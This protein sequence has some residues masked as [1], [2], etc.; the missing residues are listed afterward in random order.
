[1]GVL[2]HY[3]GD[4]KLDR[5]FILTEN[6][7]PFGANV[8]MRLSGSTISNLELLNNSTSGT[9]KGSLFWVLNH[10]KTAFGARLLKRWVQQPL[11]N[12]AYPNPNPNTIP[13]TSPHP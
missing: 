3:L 7:H 5:V 1:M 12:P 9:E 6:I 13:Y 8:A 11:I 4:F 2:L 10:T